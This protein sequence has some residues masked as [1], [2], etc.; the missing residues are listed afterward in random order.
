MHTPAPSGALACESLEAMEVGKQIPN[1]W[2]SLP[3]S[4]GEE[5]TAGTVRAAS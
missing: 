4:Y 1:T 3:T 5:P 2:R